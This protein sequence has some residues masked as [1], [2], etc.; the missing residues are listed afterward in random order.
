MIKAESFFFFK[1]KSDTVHVL[2]RKHRLIEQ[3]IAFSVSE[4]A[5]SLFNLTITRENYY[6][7]VNVSHYQRWVD[8]EVK[9]AAS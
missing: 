7:F 9:W 2:T 3:D 1:D 6:T 5:P 4:N 8:F